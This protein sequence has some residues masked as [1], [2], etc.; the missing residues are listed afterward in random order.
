MHRDMILILDFGGSQSQAV[1]RKVRGEQVYCE[2][3]PCGTPMDLIR[4]RKPKGL[5]LTGMP[6]EDAAEEPFCSPEIFELG[7][8]VLAL[9]YA[10][11]RM[12]TYM[13]GACL[14]TA[15]ENQPARVDFSPCQLFDGLTF[16]E[17]YIVRMDEVRLWEGA[18]PLAAAGDVIAAFGDLGRQLFG[19]Q[20]TAEQND[21]DG[22]AIIANFARNICGCDD[23]WSVGAFIE[24]SL[25]GIREAMGDG[26]ALMAVSGGVDSAVCAALMHRAIG[27]R[28]HCL[29]VD[30][31]LMRKDE[32]EMVQEQFRRM[33]MEIHRV[34][35][36]SRFADRLAGIT[37][38]EEKR[39]VI[40]EEFVAVFQEE[41]RRYEQVECLVQGT[42]YPDV[43]GRYATETP[44]R[45]VGVPAPEGFTR[46]LEPLR[47]LFK[48]EVRAVGEALAVPEEIIHRQPF[49]GPGLA[50]RCLGLVT[51]EKLAILRECDAIFRE[52]IHEAGL[53]KKIWQHFAVLGDQRVSSG[54]APGYTAILRAVTGAGSSP[55]YR[56]PY[57]LLERVMERITSQ[58]PNVLRVVYDVTAKADTPVEWE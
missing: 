43:I 45:G 39:R 24:D 4:A 58:M 28:I 55:A 46:V 11:R 3:L 42:I 6:P 44:Q 32:P 20:F 7:V 5:M 51:G 56:M 17:R 14:K 33:Q 23:W 50:V 49:P 9:G 27:E 18:R 38:P 29:F 36:R 57:D 48:D 41:A 22:L 52:E 54:E 37:D 47:T 40:D 35:A 10:A 1:A 34:D 12:L 25:D 13:G 26:S 8:P 53:D 31:G 2:V 30:T 21:P 19:L 15:I 16:S